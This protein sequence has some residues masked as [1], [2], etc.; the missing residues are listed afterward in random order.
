VE[1]VDDERDAEHPIGDEGLL[2][3]W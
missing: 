2:F 3:W 1:L